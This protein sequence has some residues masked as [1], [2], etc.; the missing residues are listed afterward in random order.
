MIDGCEP[1]GLEL[2]DGTRSLVG[3]KISLLG[4]RVVTMIMIM[5]TKLA[6]VIP[7]EHV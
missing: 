5:V 4:G 7:S 2:K 6:V 3:I 1:S